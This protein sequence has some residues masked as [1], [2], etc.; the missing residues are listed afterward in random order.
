[1]ERAVANETSG[2]FRGVIFDF[3]GVLFWDNPLHEE[4]WRQY[5]RRLR[6]Y[7][8]TD[9]EME[10]QVHGRV[11]LDI[12]TFILDRTPSPDT[13]DAMAEE[14]EAIYRQL[15][16][17]A[18]EAIRLSPGAVELLDYLVAHD[19]PHTIATSSAWPNVA[20][21]IEQLQLGRWFDLKR[22]VYDK[23][24][25]PG[26]PAPHIYREAAAVLGLPAGDCIVVED[27]LAG[28][29]SARVA[30]IGY[31]VALGPAG[32]RDALAAL[33]GVDAVIVD[34]HHFPRHL[35]LAP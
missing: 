21:Y 14:K 29:E 22:L 35:L 33:P 30:G 19:I 27:S 3:N 25:Y 26:K 12:F 24:D 4:A 15:C 31:V 7:P 10:E 6:G 13:L 20:F 8:L 9:R 18:G 28:I 5:S 32:R 17:E 34:L 1:M 2:L 23:G 16:L 11:N